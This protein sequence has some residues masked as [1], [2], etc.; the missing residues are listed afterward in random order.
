MV[1]KWSRID[2]RGYGGKDR[3]VFFKQGEKIQR[4]ALGWDCPLEPSSPPRP[5][6]QLAPPPRCGCTGVAPDGPP[7][8]GSAFW[9]GGCCRV[10]RVPRS[11]SLA[12]R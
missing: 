11:Y 5:P 12:H 3:L 6:S 7:A 9:Q 1:L 10:G 8:A 4:E 2:Q